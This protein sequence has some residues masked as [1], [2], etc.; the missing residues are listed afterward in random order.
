MTGE[1]REK[2]TPTKSW[3]HRQRVSSTLHIF[4]WSDLHTHFPRSWTLKLPFVSFAKT[5]NLLNCI[6]S[7][8]VCFLNRTFV[9]KKDL[10]RALEKDTRDIIQKLRE[11]HWLELGPQSKLGLLRPT[12]ARADR[13]EKGRQ[14]QLIFGERFT[15]LNYCLIKY[16]N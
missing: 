13:M 7:L 4:K 1:R 12:P 11:R 3:Y 8:F 5:S 14:H 2:D 15:D 10:L 6:N 16:L 9:F